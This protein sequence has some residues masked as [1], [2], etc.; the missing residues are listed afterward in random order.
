MPHATNEGERFVIFGVLIVQPM[1]EGCFYIVTIPDEGRPYSPLNINP[2][3]RGE[4]AFKNEMVVWFIVLFA[5]VAST[6]PS[7]VPTL[8]FI[9]SGRLIE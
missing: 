4:G 2:D 8:K 3:C 7:E 9:P 5:K 1:F 6:R